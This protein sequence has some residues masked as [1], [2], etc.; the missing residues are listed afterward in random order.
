MFRLLLI[1]VLT[2]L[3]CLSAATY[4]AV[5]NQISYAIGPDYFHAFKFAQFRIPDELPPRIGAALVGVQASWWMGL[6]IG[7][8]IALI[9]AFAPSARIMF[10]LFVITA[11]SVVALTLALGLATLLLPVD[12]VADQIAM[13]R[14]VRDATGF[15]RAALMHDTAYLAG[16]LG[17]AVGIVMAIRG[18]IRSR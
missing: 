5:H 18:V 8:P 11:I 16:A 3:A 2:L 4:G 1:P 17:L 14:G 12:L 6:I 9:C 7:L 15:A 10:R 13:P